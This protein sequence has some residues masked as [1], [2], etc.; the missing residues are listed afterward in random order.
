M[1][2]DIPTREGVSASVEAVRSGELAD[3][4]RFNEVTV[5]L[6]ILMRAKSLLSP[7]VHTSQFE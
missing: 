6:I 3:K 4:H 1:W 5:L 2:S 7:A